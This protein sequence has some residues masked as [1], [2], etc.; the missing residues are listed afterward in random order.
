MTAQTTHLAVRREVTVEVGIER[1]F[2]VFTRRLD[3][4]WPHDTHHLGPMPAGPRP[5]LRPARAARLRLAADARLELRA[6]P[7]EGS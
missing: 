2:E 6:R 7:G 3:A 5:G 4:W 1:A